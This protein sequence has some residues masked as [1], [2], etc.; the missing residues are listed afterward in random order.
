MLDLAALAAPYR[1]TFFL[2][3]VRMGAML[4][5]AP[6][7]GHRS[8]PLVYRAG[9]A[10]FLALVLTPVLAPAPGGAHHDAFGLLLAVSGEVLVGVAIGFVASLV[11][12]AVRSATEIVGFQM[13]LGL[14]AVFDP[15]MGQP[16]TALTR[17][18]ETVALLVFLSVWGHHAVIQV[19]AASFHR[20]PPGVFPALAP[21]GAGALTLGGKLLRSGLELAAP[22]IGLLFVV[23]VV[24]ALLARVAPQMNV[25]AVGVPLAVGVGIVGLV[26]TAPYFFGI[27]ARLASEVGRDVTT[28]L[29]GAA[30]GF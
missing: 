20:I 17:F 27:V 30:R 22:L 3:F 5:I 16:A 19:A 11:I 2:V 13:G 28:L 9:L 10:A 25:F 15:V 18:Q 14:G 23:N 8:I 1:E 26:E 6:V 21:I 12:A 24:M 4:S 29:V 7:L